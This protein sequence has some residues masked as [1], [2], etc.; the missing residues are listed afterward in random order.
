MTAERYTVVFTGLFDAKKPGEYYYL[1]IDERPVA[2]GSYEL[3]NGQPPYGEF[4]R[5]IGFQDL[6]DGC[7]KLATEVYRDLWS[8]TD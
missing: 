1:T 3:H 8:L 2:N 6:P 7:Q 5:E 4:R